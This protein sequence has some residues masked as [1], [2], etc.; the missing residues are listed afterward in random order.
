[1]NTR[2][3]FV[4][5]ALLLSGIPAGRE[6]SAR[7]LRAPPALPQQGDPGPV[8]LPNKPG[9]LKFAAWGDF[10]NGEAAQYETATQIVKTHVAFP[11]EFVVTLGDNLYGAERPQ[12]FVVKFERPYKPLL[13]AGVKFYASLG[14]HDAREQRNYKLFNMNDK[15]YYSFKAPVQDVRFFALESTYMT[16]D[17]V[18]WLENELK[19]SNS[20]WKIVY[21]HH[22]LY[23]SGATHGSSL[24]LR[25]TLEPLFVKYGVRVVLTGHDHIYERIKPQQGI[26]HF[27]VGSGG[28]LR[29]GD[30]RKTAMTDV[31]FDTDNV[32]LVAEIIDDTMY[33]N[34][35]SRTGKIVD[36]GRIILQKPAK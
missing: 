9:S 17:Q 26:T 28:Q 14:N 3:L 33:F 29:R 12:D 10:G 25:Q 30:L 27:V 22:P 7:A 13:D 18:A 11:F 2:R 16:P 24:A 1:M 31:G 23:S 19:G 8:Q 15:L 34:A 20:A 36:S 35:V 21:L 32:F 6:I 5:A 4:A